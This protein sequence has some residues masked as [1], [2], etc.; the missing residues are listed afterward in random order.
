MTNALGGVVGADAI[1]G[2][3]FVRH[4]DSAVAGLGG[5]VEWHSGHWVAEISLGPVRRFVIGYAFPL[6]NVASAK[7]ADDKVA[8]SVV[9]GRAGVERVEHHLLRPGWGGSPEVDWLRELPV[10][11]KPNVG[12]AG[13]GV[14]RAR[15]LDELD[16]ALAELVPDYPALAWSPFLDVT[17]EYRTVFLDGEMLLAFRKVRTN[18]D[19]WRHNLHHGAVPVVCTDQSEV[20]RLAALGR[21]AMAALGLRF[22]TVDIVGTPGGDRVLE[23]NSGVC[24]ERF[25]KHSPDGERRARE[26]YARAVAASLAST[27]G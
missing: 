27:E 4:V 19:E 26:V 10:V 18:P 23:V 21:G 2:R 14:H 6:N 25:G 13:R 9:L 8:T 15:T 11:V 1:S 17:D 24:L 3:Q 16:K 7:V 12:S 20:D 5:R 22:A